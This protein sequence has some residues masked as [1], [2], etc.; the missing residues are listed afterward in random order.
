MRRGRE[1]MCVYTRERQR[2]RKSRSENWHLSISC[3]SNACTASP[4]FLLS[5]SPWPVIAW[6][7][8]GCALTGSWRQELQPEIISGFYDVARRR[9][10]WQ[11]NHYAKWSPWSYIFK[12]IRYGLWGWLCQL[13]ATSQWPVPWEQAGGH[14]VT[15]P[16]SPWRNDRDLCT[17]LCF[18]ADTKQGAALWLKIY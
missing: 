10:S 15:L 3:P 4:T 9:L 13:D 1:S 14:E 12:M 11:L 5:H 6:C 8:P 2:E 16:V 18:K 17:G 7:L